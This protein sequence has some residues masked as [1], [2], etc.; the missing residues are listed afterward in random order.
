AAAPRPAHTRARN[1][2]PR[3]T[4]T[5]SKTSPT[6]SPPPASPPGNLW[7][8]GHGNPELNDAALEARAPPPRRPE[9]RHSG[10]SG[11]RIRRRNT[12]LPGLHRP[13]ERGDGVGAELDPGRPPDLCQRERRFEPRPVDAVGDHGVERVSKVDD[14]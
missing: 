11:A 2:S 6:N 1:D 12:N 14:G 9:L 13:L 10:E 7:L 8:T 5:C 3:S 4:A